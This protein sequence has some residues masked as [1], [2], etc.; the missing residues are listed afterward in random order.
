MNYLKQKGIIHKDIKTENIMLD[1]SLIKII[2]FGYSFN[3]KKVLSLFE[4][5]LLD[6]VIYGT[7]DYIA[8]ERIE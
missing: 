6:N 7:P 4:T 3:S 1:D 2:D 8:P 5:N